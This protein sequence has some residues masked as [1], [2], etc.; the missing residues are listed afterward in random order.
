MPK[1]R[2]IERTEIENIVANL[3]IK[4]ILDSVEENLNCN[5]NP[6]Q[7]FLRERG[8]EKGLG[9]KGLVRKSAEFVHD[10]FY[11]YLTIKLINQETR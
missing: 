1:F 2:N 3:T 6:L 9:S 5:T 4:R 10:H 7:S 11:Q 8:R